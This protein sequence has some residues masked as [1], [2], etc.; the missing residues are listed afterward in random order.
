MTYETPQ[1]VLVDAAEA[2]VLGDLDGTFDGAGTP[3][4]ERVEMDLTLGLDD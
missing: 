1:L 4:N 3:P 2:L